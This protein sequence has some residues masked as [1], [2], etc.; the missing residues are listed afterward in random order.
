MKKTLKLVLTVLLVTSFVFCASS[1]V[2]SASTD[3]CVQSL[4]EKDSSGKLI[5]SVTADSAVI[6]NTYILSFRDVTTQYDYLSS[7]T[8]FGDGKVG[9][10][11]SAYDI[12]FSE[13]GVKQSV[14][15]VFEVKLLLPVS[16]RGQDFA[17]KLIHVSD[18]GE[19]SEIAPSL[20]GDY[21]VFSVSDFSVFAI[22]NVDDAPIPPVYADYSWVKPAI[23]A[24][25]VLII[26]ALIILLIIKK[27]KK[28]DPEDAPAPKPAPIPQAPVAEEPAKEEQATA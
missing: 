21:L 15:S 23:V 11:V 9:Y 12:H 18:S 25:V 16:L 5:A 27:R 13:G 22:V 3:D 28:N 26:L 14:D 6:P 20:Q 2:A 24:A 19:I 8:V 1:V 10:V 4:T 7:E 17:G